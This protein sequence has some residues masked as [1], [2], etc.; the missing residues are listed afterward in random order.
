MEQCTTNSNYCK[1]I[2]EKIVLVLLL[3]TLPFSSLAQY[4]ANPFPMVSTSDHSKGDGFVQA[5]GMKIELS[6]IY[7]GSDKSEIQILAGGA[8]QYKQGN[9]LFFL[10][11]FNIDGAE[12]GWRSMLTDSW[13]VQAG[14]RHETVLPKSDI[15]EANIQGLSHRGSSLFGFVEGTYLF[16]KKERYWLTGRLSAGPS[17]FGYRAKVSVGHSFAR[18][19]E[20]SGLDVV[21]YSTFGD[22]TQFDRFFGISAE[23]SLSSGLT[24]SNLDGGYRSSGLEIL[25]RQN[26]VTNIQIFAK[27]GVELYSSDIEESALVSDDTD[28]TVEISVVWRFW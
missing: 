22:D 27:V 14:I 13:L 23:E 10:E 9:H 20:G 4:Y 3:L 11:G 28:T 5:F 15:K 26:L 21:A 17:D 19:A 12:M 16:G 24:Q 18:T 6:P 25:Y 7:D 8:L 1:Y 2:L